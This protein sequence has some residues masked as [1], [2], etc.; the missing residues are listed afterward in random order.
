MAARTEHSLAGVEIFGS[1]P[2]SSLQQFEKRCLWR[3]YRR[4]ELVIGHLDDSNNVFFLVSGTARVVI[5]S[6]SGKSVAF[7][8]IGAGDMVGEFAALD[9][10][11]RSASVEAL[12]DC[13]IAI[14]AA[15]DFLEL[16]EKESSAAV[17]LLVNMVARLRQLTSRVYEFSTLAV[18]NRI[19]AELLRLARGSSGEGNSVVILPA[20]TQAE[21]ASRISTHREAVSR[22]FSRLAKLDLVVRDGAGLRINNVERLARMVEK[23]IQE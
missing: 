15:A 6:A 2:E 13:V 19:H 23:A 20:P 21:I 5:Y 16:L 11:P 12:D 4:G 8:D 9:S 18:Q 3:S 14:M 17:A 22:E 7:R 10:K 1:L